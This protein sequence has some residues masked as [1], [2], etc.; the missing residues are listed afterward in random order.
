MSI[1]VTL[2]R[3]L[4][5]FERL[6]KNCT[7][8]RLGTGAGQDVAKTWQTAL[9]G[10]GSNKRGWPTTHFWAGAARSVNWQ[11]SATGATVS[12]NQIGVRQRF[13][14]GRISPVNAR[15]L[16][17][18]ISPISYGHVASDFPG[19]FL[20]KTSKGAYLAQKQEGPQKGT[21]E[22]KADKG[23]R[24]RGMGGNA[25][26]RITAGLNLLFKLSGGVNQAPDPRVVPHDALAAAAVRGAQRALGTL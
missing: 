12:C 15:A 4:R 17:I 9:R 8:E 22:T 14:G 13:H 20:L 2:A 26:R 11:A 24:L 19:L 10:L 3:D 6:K 18:P 16:T 7:P 21:K 25:S 23:K 5:Q 1:T